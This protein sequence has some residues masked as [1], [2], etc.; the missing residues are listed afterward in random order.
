MR[1]AAQCQHGGPEVSCMHCGQLQPGRWTPGCF[2][3]IRS[4][5]RSSRRRYRSRRRLEWALKSEPNESTEASESDSAP[6]V[7]PAS[8]LLPFSAS[9]IAVGVSKVNISRDISKL[10]VRLTQSRC[11]RLDGVIFALVQIGDQEVK[12]C[13]ILLWQHNGLAF[14][15]SKGSS[16]GLLEIFRLHQD[17]L[18][19]LAI[20]S[21]QR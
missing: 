19:H 20:V 4:R 1:G 10:G 7:T 18:V 11:N 13:G 21:T 3:L 17:L 8:L 2:C 5:R 6:V 12:E 15:L 16:Q 14:R 9:S